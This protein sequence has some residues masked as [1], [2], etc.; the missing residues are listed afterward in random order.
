MLSPVRLF[1]DSKKPNISPYGGGGG[2][3]AEPRMMMMKD[4]SM[5]TGTNHNGGRVIEFERSD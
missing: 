1:A 4:A 3:V 2:K 5:S